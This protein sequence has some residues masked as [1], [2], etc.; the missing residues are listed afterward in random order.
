M[1]LARHQREGFS[2]IELMVVVAIIGILM[3]AG[4][5]AFSGAQRNA[6]DAK[7]KADIDAI[8]KAQEQYLATNGTYLVF[9][10]WIALP[11]SLGTAFFPSGATPNDPLNRQ[12]GLGSYGMSASTNAFCVFAPL[13]RPTG[14]CT[15]LSAGFGG[16]ACA[17]VTP[18]TGTF[19][20]ASQRQ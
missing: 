19:Q 12:G 10:N 8:A 6:R 5:I 20:C 7:R 15:G 17:Y 9:A 2:L 11:T 18:G 1:F 16:Y 13:E 4:I 3:A 14:N